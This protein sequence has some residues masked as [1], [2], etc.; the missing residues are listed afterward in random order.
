MTIFTKLQATLSFA[1]LGV[2]LG[3]AACGG[4]G[5]DGASGASSNPNVGG[6]AQ[7]VSG[8]AAKG[9]A[10]VGAAVTL[11][12]ANGAAL[13]GNTSGT[14]QYT[15]AATSIAY[16]CIGTAV[17]V[18]GVPSY[19]TVLFSGGVANF[20]PLT[21]MLVQTVLA[22]SASG[23]ASL[24]VADFI[25]KMSG[26]ATFSASVSSAA[27]VTAY[28]AVVLATVRKELSATNTPTQID[29]ILAAAST[30]DSTPFVTGSALDQ[31]LDN[32]AS[33]LQNAD[34]SV[35]AAVLLDAKSNAD[36][37]PLPSS[38]ATGATGSSGT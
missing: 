10:L 33:V 27:N 5:S 3:L 7:S 29:A 1:S 9:T 20:S 34:G 11:T 26:D 31:V 16:P 30:F 17:A 13:S 6:S 32:T 37:L 36:V 4:G 18:G 2:V 38:K 22:A 28:R 21:D 25:T 19:R 24:T 8:T 14:G 15:T 23:S 35:N 12:C